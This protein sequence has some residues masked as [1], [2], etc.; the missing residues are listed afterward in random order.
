MKNKLLVVTV[1]LILAA[2]LLFGI[3]PVAAA[4]SPSTTT[5][6]VTQQAGNGHLWVRILSVPDQANLDTLLAK[7]EANGKITT[8]QAAKIESFWTE[9]RAKFVKVVKA[10]ILQRLLSVKSEANL[11]TFLDKQVAASKISAAQESTIISMWESAHAT[12]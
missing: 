6:P 12:G 5:P 7:A 10:R 4:D 11:K 8:A 2:V 3:I 1:G 9:Y